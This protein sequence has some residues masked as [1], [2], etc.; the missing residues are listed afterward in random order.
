MKNIM[1]CIAFWGIGFSMW[2]YLNEGGFEQ[3]PLARII[4]L[5]CATAYLITREDEGDKDEQR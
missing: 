2:E 1:L 3:W 5:S 4:V